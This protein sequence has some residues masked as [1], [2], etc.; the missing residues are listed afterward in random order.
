MAGLDDRLAG[1]LLPPAAQWIDD[2]VLPAEG[3]DALRLRRW[4]AGRM[5]RDLGRWNVSPAV[6]GP[7]AA[8]Y[9]PA[10]AGPLD[11][12]PDSGPRLVRRTWGTCTFEGLPPQRAGLFSR[13]S[14]RQAAALYWTDGTRPV[15]A[16]ERLTGAECGPAPEGGLL[17]LAEACVDAG[18]ADWA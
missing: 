2:R 5:L 15:A 10:A 16:V 6:Y 14:L 12:L 3:V 9:C 13:W 1:G 17:P 4:V 11:G 7:H 8:R 18:L